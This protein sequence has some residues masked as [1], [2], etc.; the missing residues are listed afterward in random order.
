MKP[1]I[2]CANIMTGRIGAEFPRAAWLRSTG[3]GDAAR[4]CN[5]PRSIPLRAMLCLDPVI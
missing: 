5:D 1:L 4:L 2:K 3:A